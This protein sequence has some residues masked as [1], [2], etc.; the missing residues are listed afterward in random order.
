MTGTSASD[1]T[2]T[3]TEPDT[4]RLRACLAEVAA[5]QCRASF[6]VLF[7][8]F[9]PRLKGFLMR[10]GL[11]EAS[12][13][14]LVQEVMLTIWNKAG[15]YD[16]KAAAPSTW[17][18]TI[19]RNRRVD[20]ARR[21]AVRKVPDGVQ[22][23]LEPKAEKAPDQTAAEGQLAGRMGQ[24]LKSLPPEQSELIRAAYY[25]GLAHSEIAA[26]TGLPLGT[27]KSRIRL[28]MKRLKAELD[29]LSGDLLEL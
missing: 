11:R 8:Y 13:E 22:E 26:S 12:T 29:G 16:P 14:E 21:H 24:A 5:R 1:T 9:A 19:A 3:T 4:D 10:Q 25:K 7:R 27:V 6:A 2:H 18:F 17:V 28:G 23:E 15:T 20:L